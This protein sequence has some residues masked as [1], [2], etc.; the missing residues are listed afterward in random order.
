MPTVSQQTYDRSR[1]IVTLQFIQGRT[2]GDYELNELQSILVDRIGAALASAGGFGPVG[3]ALRVVAS[4]TGDSNTIEIL[5]GVFIT[6]R[7]RV[8]YVAEPVVLDTLTTSPGSRTDTVYLLVD[9][10]LKDEI[11]FPNILNPSNGAQLALRIS[12]DLTLGFTEGG[13]PATPTDFV[14]E[15]VEL[16]TITRATATPVVLQS[17]ITDVR[18]QYAST[19][20]SSGGRLTLPG[21]L[22]VDVAAISGKVSGVPFALADDTLTL[23]NDDTSLVYISSA[24]V[25]TAS[26]TRPYGPVAELYVVTTESG[27]VTEVLDYRVQSP[28]SVLS[29]VVESVRIDSGADQFLAFVDGSS[30]LAI[31]PANLPSGAT[32]A[33]TTGF[34]GSPSWTN[35]VVNYLSWDISGAALSNQT[36]SWPSSGAIPLWEVTVDGSGNITSIADRRPQ[37]SFIPDDPTYALADLTDVSADLSAAIRDTSVLRASPADAANP[38]ATLADLPSIPDFS[39]VPVTHASLPSAGNTSTGVVTA[40]GA[41]NF[42]LPLAGFAGTGYDASLVRGFFVMTTTSSDTDAWFISIRF[43]DGAVKDINVVDPVA[44]PDDRHASVCLF[45]PVAPGQ[46]NVDVTITRTGGGTGSGGA[47]LVFY[48]ALQFG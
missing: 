6:P 5:P 3:E 22:D 38:L 21:G 9:E 19:Y 31:G 34:G 1:N 18:P 47:E 13:T 40:L 35:S 14:S 30:T 33:G 43:P 11:T 2:V 12:S 24:G 10:S 27:A 32:Y 7:G 20:V 17:E 37:F 23:A 26:T 46:V 15:I 8:V 16:A 4:S 29:S 45:V 25:L 41:T 36:G 28:G 48:G 39:F 44:G 42:L